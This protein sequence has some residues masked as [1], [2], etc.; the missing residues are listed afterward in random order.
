MLLNTETSTNAGIALMAMD[1]GGA[2]P[3]AELQEN[4]TK[5]ATEAKALFDA[6]MHKNH[7]AQGDPKADADTCD[8]A[9]NRRQIL[10]HTKSILDGR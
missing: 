6:L 9:C 3:L 5:M 2:F 8:L 7:V 4:D 10:A 1:I